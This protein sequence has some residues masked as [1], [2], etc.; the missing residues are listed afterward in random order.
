LAFDAFGRLFAV[1]NDPDERPPCRLLHIVPGGDYGYRYRNGRRGL[2]PFTAWDG[3]LPGTLPMVAGTGEAPSGILAYEAGGLPEDYRGTL[4]VTS[5]GDHV[6]QRFRLKERGASF[7]AESEAVVKGGEDFRPVGIAAAPDGSLVLSDWVKYDYPVHQKGRLWR[8]RWRQ[9]V[10]APPRGPDDPRERLRALWTGGVE[11]GRALEDPAPE[12]RAEAARMLAEAGGQEERLLDRALAEEH[13]RVRF[14]AILGLRSRAGVERVL[15]LVA[16]P[17]PFLVSAALEA[18]AKGGDSEFLMQSRESQDPRVRL[19]VLV[20]LRRT[21][22]RAGL[23]EFLK[24]PDPGVRRAA[25]QWVG[26]EGL[27]ELAERMESAASQPPVTREVFSAYLAASEFIHRGGAPGEEHAGEE[28]IVGILSEA[29]QAPALRSLAL[30]LLRPDHPALTAERLTGLLAAE[31]ARLQVDAAFALGGIASDR[32]QRSL[33]WVARDRGAPLE[34]RA[35]AALGLSASS[36]HDLIALLEGEPW[37]LQREA[38]QSLGGALGEPGVPEA[39]T[40]WSRRIPEMEEAVRPDAAEKFL[41]VVTQDPNLRGRAMFSPPVA[42]AGRRPETE[43]EWK[44]AIEGPGDAAAGERVY[45]HPRGPQCFVCHRVNGRGGEVGPALSAIG[46]TLNAERMIDSIL[47]PAREIAPA[48]GG[49]EI[50][51]KEGETLT[52][53]IVGEDATSITLLSALGTRLTL[54]KDVVRERRAYKASIMPEG[55]HLALTR[56][57]FRDLMAFLYGLR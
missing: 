15:P 26:E 20:A 37:A 56:Q 39:L 40:Q 5:W 53:R 45:F 13:P 55:L 47:A 51:T 30:R 12:V 11:P 35:A 57:E 23:R 43:P 32:A 2:H 6:L 24:D 44:K 46:R 28:Y 41:L 8:V 7:G 19:G 49:W 3:E 29:G 38:L 36:R 14:H 22:N 50:V 48:Y 18:L 17:D 52:G 25:I 10:A 1:D 16:D 21:G 9:P 54:P 4:L 31:D 33:R 34:V 42:T 27:Q